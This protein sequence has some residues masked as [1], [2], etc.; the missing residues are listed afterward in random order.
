MFPNKN[1]SDK[2]PS[3]SRLLSN[4]EK[5]SNEEIYFRLKLS[6]SNIFE[7]CK[8]SVYQIS[9][10]IIEKRKFKEEIEKYQTQYVT[11]VKSLSKVP[12]NTKETYFPAET[13][14]ALFLECNNELMR[15]CA[16][17]AKNQGYLNN[18]V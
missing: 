16:I 10:C 8:P 11:G 17:N 1:D 3:V 9:N 7:A 4:N 5:P 14:L 15:E 18:L 13:S 2:V 12:R 6:Q